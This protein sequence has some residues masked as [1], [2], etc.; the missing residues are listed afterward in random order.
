MKSFCLSGSL[1]KVVIRGKREGEM[2]KRRRLKGNKGSINIGESLHL[3]LK[4]CYT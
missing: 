3:V 1:W 4:M 2:V